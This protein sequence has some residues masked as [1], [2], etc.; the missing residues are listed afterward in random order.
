[1]APL[2]DRLGTAE[3]KRAWLA[4]LL[5]G[6]MVGA[7]AVTEPHAG[8]DYAALRTKAVQ[9]RGHTVLNGT[10]TYVT[11]ANAAQLLV[12][13]AR[14]AGGLSLFLVPRDAPGA[15]VTP[16]RMLGL[17]PSDPGRIELKNC[18]IPP[19]NR[20]G[21]RGAGF[22]YIQQVLNRER[23]LG[24]LACIAWAHHAMARTI[25]FARERIAFGQPLTRIAVIRH[26][27]AEMATTL[28]AAHQLNQAVFTRWADGKDMT[29]EICMIK[30]FSYQTALRVIDQCLQIHGGAG[31]LDQSWIARFY[32]DAR[33]LTIAAGTPEIMKEVIAASMRL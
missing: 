26:Q 11:C 1:V 29:K 15:R 3:Q 25:A 31:Y 33:A 2:L 30:L 12:V 7:L 5:R 27:F 23:L 9:K 18:R 28:E 32:R 16:L 21:E 17:H 13:A 10:K 22:G 4:P 20:L 6:T 8:S 19:A 14:E 24:G